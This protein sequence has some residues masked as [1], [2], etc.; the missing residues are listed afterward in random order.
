MGKSTVFANNQGIANKNSGDTVVSSTPDVCLTPVGG[1]F[2]PTPYINT[3]DSSSLADGSKT[4]TID[5]AMAAIE[6]SCYK[7]STGDE[8]GTGGGIASGTVGDKAV[9]INCSFDVKIEGKGVCR[10]FDPMTMNNRNTIGINQGSTNSSNVGKKEYV[11][12]DTFKF[13]VY[14][15]C[16]WDHYDEEGKKFKPGTIHNKLLPGVK[17][18][19]IMRDKD[20]NFVEERTV[21]SNENG[22]VEIEEVPVNHFFDIIFEPENAED[23]N[24]YTLHYNCYADFD[25]NDPTKEGPPADI[26]GRPP[27]RKCMEQNDPEGPVLEYIKTDCQCGNNHTVSIGYPFSIFDAHMHIQSGRCAPMDFIY[28]QTPYVGGI[29]KRINL[30][31][32]KMEG[33]GKY[34]KEKFVQQGENPTDVNGGDYLKEQ[35]RALEEYFI[36]NSLYKDILNISFCGIVM[37]MD[38]EYSHI[39]GYYG[40]KAYN[41]IWKNS[42]EDKVHGEAANRP[43]RYWTP[44]HGYWKGF[45]TLVWEFFTKRDYR[46]VKPVS[47]GEKLEITNFATLEEFYSFKKEGKTVTGVY[48]TF[49][50]NDQDD[51]ERNLTGYAPHYISI[52]AIPALLSTRETDVYENWRKQVELTEK[53]VLTNP[54]RL[55][56]LY[57]YDPR[58]WQTEPN[59]NEIPMDKVSV[60]APPV[61]KEETELNGLCLGFK[62]YSHQGWRPYDWKRLPILEEFYYKCAKYGIPLPQMVSGQ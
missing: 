19:L 1:S 50:E 31:R 51:G 42:E 55:L 5:G 6:G 14:E 60:E 35:K 44:Q 18:R 37:P 32:E 33:L 40:L 21:T 26:H 23:N 13:T 34:F 16:S 9:F 3:A 29:L 48:Y 15:Y 17:F 25:T 8:P 53:A 7:T 61:K 57:H 52:D 62:S 38:M 49:P 12:D 43:A 46:P 54:L 20:K 58:R 24:K 2:V 39:D 27:Y 56:P 4:V 45:V 11:A 47:P 22:V 41:P 59:G 10:N 36:G 28:K 30:S